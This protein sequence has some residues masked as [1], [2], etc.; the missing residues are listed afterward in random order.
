MKTM[1]NA[2]RLNYV[3]QYPKVKVKIDDQKQAHSILPGL[4][5]SQTKQI[6]YEEKNTR[7]RLLSPT[8][9]Q[10]FSD[11]PSSSNTK[12]VLND[13]HHQGRPSVPLITSDYN[14]SLTK[15]HHR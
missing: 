3:A 12:M 14:K 9:T 8:A 1:I 5:L 11:E 7:N 4:F 15:G 10:S 13:T 2:H 6:L